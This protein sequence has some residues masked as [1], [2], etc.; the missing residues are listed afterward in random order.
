MKQEPWDRV[1]IFGLILNLGFLLIDLHDGDI[2]MAYI[3]ALSAA[4][5]AALYR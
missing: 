1:L 5:C 2:G 4:L 3:N